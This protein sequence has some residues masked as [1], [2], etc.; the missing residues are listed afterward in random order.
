MNV[1]DV[2]IECEE[3]QSREHDPYNTVLPIPW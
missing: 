3:K 1:L 2:K